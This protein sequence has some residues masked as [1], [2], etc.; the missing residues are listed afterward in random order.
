MMD[1]TEVQDLAEDGW[2]EYHP[3]TDDYLRELGLLLEEHEQPEAMVHHS[4]Q[5]ETAIRGEDLEVSCRLCLR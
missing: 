5:L 4:S 3:E 1:P 2:V